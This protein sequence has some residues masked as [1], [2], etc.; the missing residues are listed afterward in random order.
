MMEIRLSFFIL[1]T[2]FLVTGCNKQNTLFERKLAAETGITFINSVTPND[3][4]NLLTYEYFYNGGGVAVGDVNNDGLSDIYFSGNTVTSRLYLN[5]GNLKFKDVTNQAHVGTNTWATGVTIV[6]INNDGLQDIY[7]CVADYRSDEHRKNLLFINKGISKDGIPAYAEEAEKY[8]LADNGYATQATFLDYDKDND[9]DMYLIRVNKADIDPNLIRQKNRPEQDPSVDRLYRNNGNNTFTDVS[10]EAGI[11][12]EGFGLGV[13]VADINQDGWPDLYVANDFI[14]SDQLLINNRNGTFSDSIKSYF[15]HTSQFSMGTDIADFNNDGLQ[16]IITVDMMPADNKRQKLMNGVKNYDEFQ[17]ALRRGYMPQQVR[18]NLQLNNGNGTFSEISQLAGVDQTDWSWSALFADFDND[19]NR[20]LLI[21]N[22][23]RKDITHLDFVT[24]HAMQTR[25]RFGREAADK[26]IHRMVEEMEGVKKMNYIFRNNGNLAF[27]NKAEEWGLKELSFTNGA[28]YADL[29]NDGDLDLVMNNIDDAA[30]LYENKIIK[31]DKKA[32]ST[33]RESNNYLR[34]K[35][36]GGVREHGAKVTLKYLDKKQVAEYTPYRGF[37]SSVEQALH[38]GLGLVKT[39]DSLEITWPDGKY[40]LLKNVMANHLLTMRYQDAVIKP[41]PS[42]TVHP[43]LFTE[44]SKHLGVD[45][46]HV[47]E[48]YVDFKIQPL[49]PHKYSQNGPGI[50]VGDVNGDGLEDFYVGGGTN[51]SGKLFLQDQQGIFRASSLTTQVPISDEMGSLFFD[52][53]NDNDQDLYIV[54]GGSETRPELGRYQNRLYRNDGSGNFREDKSALPTI[55]ASGSCVTAAD[56]DNDGDLDLF[57]GGR[58]QPQKYPLPVKSCILRNEGSRFVDATSVVC[59]ELNNIGLVTAAL[60]TDFDSD[61]RVDLLVA[62]EW[63]PLTFYKNTH[64]IF[65]N[66]T[67]ATGLSGN[68]GWWNSL[69]AGDFD[70]DGDT[71]YIAGNL[72][73][74]SRFKASVKEPIEVHAKDFDNNGSIDPIMSFYLEGKKYPV[75][76]RDEMVDQ[77]VTTRRDFP[78][79]ESYASK[80]FDEIYPPEKLKGTYAV[81]AENFKTSYIQNVGKGKFRIKALPVQAQLAPVFGI[82]VQDYNQDGNLDVVLT[83]NSYATE[84]LTG[85]Y[86]AF[87]GLYLQGNGKGGFTPAPVTKSGFMVDGNAKGL[88]EIILKDGRLLTLVAQNNHNLKAFVVNKPVATAAAKIIALQ[89]YDAY[90]IEH[91]TNGQK[92]KCEFYYGSGYL[93]QSSRK[94]VISNRVKS[95]QIV[96][97]RGKKRTVFL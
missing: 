23:I 94:L 11:N 53:D 55:T 84:V 72:G 44:V 49:L 26:V 96:D 63:M 48:E 36:S 43:I 19:G 20:D 38:F 73:L 27:T 64:G 74:N 30:Y 79:Y 5:Q 65:K 77:I 78:T 68:T 62:G 33:E 85:A 13:V 57:V 28:A 88:G 61:G 9:L 16:D 14:Y 35:L 70:N 39:I 93:S 80:S 10:A 95:V 67:A 22:G 37:Q 66:V 90:A 59:K 86:D 21:T 81:K 17:M 3:S 29:D 60:W 58:I 83:G 52:A 32:A 89:P 47:D 51:K 34:L 42:K 41:Q 71:D 97:Y 45:Y 31:K 46:K 24:Y 50:A 8:G 54:G 56:Y 4:L 75:P 6:D 18:N 7:V 76:G 87:I 40:Q 82:G 25:S 1:L 15:K 2:L 69:A 12:K 92:R 91:L